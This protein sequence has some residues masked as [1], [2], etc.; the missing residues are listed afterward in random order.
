MEKIF[1]PFYTTK[2]RGLGLGLA[3]VKNVI[4]GHN[5]QIAIESQ[6]G[7]GTTFA[8]AIPIRGENVKRET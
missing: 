6:I 4:V 8:V 7:I 1:E 5:G 3:I 2:P